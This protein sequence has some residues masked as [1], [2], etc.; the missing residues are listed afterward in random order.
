MADGRL[1]GL[2]PG[3]GRGRAF[4][5]RLLL[6]L[7]APLASWAAIYEPTAGAASGAASP[8]PFLGEGDLGGVASRAR[9]LQG[10]KGGKY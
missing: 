1:P 7:E 4:P 3:I 6:D 8:P 10:L 5:G 2:A 9:N